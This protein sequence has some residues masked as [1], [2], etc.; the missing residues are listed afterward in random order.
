MTKIREKW[1]MPGENRG[2][3][4]SRAKLGA[5]FVRRKDHTL[6]SGNVPKISDSTNFFGA[7]ITLPSLM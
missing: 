7:T 5:I 4:T 1:K 2:D 6:H 3:R